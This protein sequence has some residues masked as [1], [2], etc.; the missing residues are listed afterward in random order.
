M[1]KKAITKRVARL[2]ESE[3]VA[4][5]KK[6]ADIYKRR[7]EKIEAKKKKKTKKAIKKYIKQKGEDIINQM[8]SPFTMYGQASSPLTSGSPLAKRGCTG[9][10]KKS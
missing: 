5:Q 4:K 8:S 7:D 2:L 9:R 1:P 3:D 10:Y 6:G